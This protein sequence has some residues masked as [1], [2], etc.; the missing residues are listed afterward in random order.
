MSNTTPQSTRV[1]DLISLL[2][3]HWLLLAVPLALCTLAALWFAFKPKMWEARQSLA[4]RDDLIGESFK[5]GRFDSLDSMKTAQETILHIATDYGVVKGALEMIGPP[6]GK[7][8]KWLDGKGGM[9]NVEAAREN[10]S[11]I[12]PNGA[13]FGKTEVIILKVQTNS[14]ER[15][16]KFVTALLDQIEA[17]LRT[18][19]S[20]RLQ[21]MEAELGQALELA[22]K[23]YSEFSQELLDLENQ[24]GSDLPILLSMT[25]DSYS[26]ND[27][28][29][30]LE[31]LR[32]AQRSAK[33]DYQELVALLDVLETTS[34][35][36]E[37]LVATPDQLLEKQPAIKRLKDGLVDAQLALSTLRGQYEEL[38]PQVVKARYA[39]QETAAQIRQ[40]LLTSMNGLSNQMSIQK[41]RV[42]RLSIEQNQLEERL[43]RLTSS[44]GR[45]A[46]LSSES[47]TRNDELASARNQYAEIKSLGAAA[48]TV[49][50]LSRLDKEP[51]VDGKP[52]G[53][54]KT[55]ILGSGILG[56]LLIGTGLIMFF[57]GPSLP[58]VQQPV[59]P[60]P[61]RPEGPSHPGS[62]SA[63]PDRTD[64]A[65]MG[66][67]RVAP[68]TP[69]TYQP[70]VPPVAVNRLAEPSRPTPAATP[71]VTSLPVPPSPP[72]P[73]QQAPTRGANPFADY[74]TDSVFSGTGFSAEL[75]ENLQGDTPA[76]PETQGQTES[77]RP[78]EEQ[79]N[80]NGLSSEQSRNTQLRPVQVVR[81]LEPNQPPAHLTAS[82]NVPPVDVSS[83]S[84]ISKADTVVAEDYSSKRTPV[85]TIKLDEI[86]GISKSVVPPTIN[87]AEHRELN[88]DQLEQVLNAAKPDAA[89]TSEFGNVAQAVNEAA[90]QAS[91]TE[92]G[93]DQAFNN[94]LVN[95]SRANVESVSSRGSQQEQPQQTID[96][97]TLRAELGASPISQS[98]PQSSR[99]SGDTVGFDEPQS[100]S[101]AGLSETATKTEST[102]TTPP[103]LEPLDSLQ[104]RIRQLTNPSR[105]MRTQLP[106]DKS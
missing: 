25:N 102:P 57:A 26:Q 6:S 77:N 85:S 58:L 33:D 14:R 7:G 29:I 51:Y 88:T 97:N 21:S 16:A 76:A 48:S 55:T 61:N 65:A 46:T 28:Q 53:P 64:Q 86:D 5:P 87:P 49:N 54:G 71:A 78:F 23:D 39:V 38:H 8:K 67:G 101:K 20:Q 63:N 92:Q 24:V 17:K 41:N 42:E 74:Q 84:D 1:S 27:I 3:K 59:S 70:E 105:T 19:R 81:N 93:I 79:P 95:D 4:V 22:Q 83:E 35:N 90:D 94:R 50:L 44:R 89:E 18:L 91:L 103:G 11:L 30:A 37:A 60:D 13:E 43:L 98:D 10:I 45:Y 36:P 34:N 40:E 100:Q 32:L 31:N 15:S 82:E 47:K 106:E 96:L 56:G 69:E 73:D 62:A 12:A 2:R 99:V 9:Q 75:N 68:P 52:L 104:E 80:I 72:S 66:Q